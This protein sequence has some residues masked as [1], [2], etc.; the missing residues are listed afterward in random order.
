[1]T[2]AKLPKRQTLNGEES[3]WDKKHDWIAATSEGTKIMFEN[4]AHEPKPI[5]VEFIMT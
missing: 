3:N 5:I 2:T 1:M 4:S